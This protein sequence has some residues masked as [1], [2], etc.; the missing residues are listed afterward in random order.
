L[1]LIVNVFEFQTGSGRACSKA[2]L[3]RMQPREIPAR[4]GGSL[5]YTNYLHLSTVIIEML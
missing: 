5:R 4:F 1:I 2:E 3:V